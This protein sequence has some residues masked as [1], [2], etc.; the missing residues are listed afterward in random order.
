[1]VGGAGLCADRF[2]IRSYPTIRMVNR[3]RGTQQEYHNS[4]DLQVRMWGGLRTYE[5]LDVTQVCGVSVF[6]VLVA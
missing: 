3:E 6:V 4:L 5:A 1:M 2:A